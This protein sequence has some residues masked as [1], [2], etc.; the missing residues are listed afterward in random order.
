MRR[1]PGSCSIF[2]LLEA[3]TVVSFSW[4]ERVE[5][6]FAGHAT[7]WYRTY[8]SYASTSSHS[9]LS[10]ATAF[11]GNG[12][13]VLPL[14]SNHCPACLDKADRTQGYRAILQENPSL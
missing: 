4:L 6:V 5:G 14:T 9:N 1:C 10:V 13:A 7:R 12:P 8:V 3:V 2:S 11:K